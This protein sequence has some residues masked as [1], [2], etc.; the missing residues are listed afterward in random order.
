MGMFPQ[1]NPRE[2]NDPVPSAAPSSDDFSAFM[3]KAM[4]KSM[5][6]SM[7]SAPLRP[8]AVPIANPSPEQP[9]DFSSFAPVQAEQPGVPV[10]TPGFPVN[11]A[12][13]PAEA[14][15]QLI[16]GAL[17]S[18]PKA[19]FDFLKSMFGN[20]NVRADYDGNFYFKKN[21]NDKDFAPVTSGMSASLLRASPEILEIGANIVAQTATQAVGVAGGV[22]GFVAGRAVAPFAGQLAQESARRAVLSSLGVDDLYNFDT[23]DVAS[24]GAFDLGAQALLSGVF[25]GVPALSRFL[26]NGSQKDRASLLAKNQKTVDWFQKEFGSA[27]EKPSDFTKSLF[28]FREEKGLLD[29]HLEKANKELESFILPARQATGDAPVPVGRVLSKL[30]DLLEKAGAIKNP[31][32]GVYSSPGKPLE[33]PETGEVI[34]LNPQK[35]SGAELGQLGGSRYVND[36]IADHAALLSAQRAGGARFEFFD[37]FRKKYGKPAFETEPGPGVKQAYNELYKAAQADRNNY[38]YRGLQGTKDM[39]SIQKAFDRVSGSISDVEMI[40]QQLGSVDAQ[41][42]AAYSLIKKGNP[43]LVRAYKRV[44]GEN[45]AEFS[46]M[47]SLWFDNLVN[48]ARDVVDDPVVL[49]DKLKKSVLSYKPETLQEL[50]IGKAEINK[51]RVA[52]ERFKS[53][54]RRDL[55]TNPKAPSSLLKDVAMLLAGGGVYFKS[56]CAVS[57]AFNLAGGNIKLVDELMNNV[58]PEMA[59]KATSQEAKTSFTEMANNLYKIVNGS[60]REGGKYKP[61][62]TPAIRPYF[63]NMGYEA[64]FRNK[65][66]PEATQPDLIGPEK[67]PGTQVDIPEGK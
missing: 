49:M 24:K 9:Q 63:S 31:R 46:Q 8:Q 7:V 3:P 33:I 28:G 34:G 37:N 48:E 42:T 4:P 66:L 58:L 12:L 13:P 51:F 54:Y 38:V 53:T 30:E 18:N 17:E 20:D 21:K 29:A 32:T 62:P 39:D 35:P 55:M 2:L 6:P 60:V 15:A 67:Q 45:S 61:I 40:R 11:P 47:K 36:M 52:A 41:E 44:L 14:R 5:P 59:E 25:E 23:A 27:P 26:R 19:Q 43:E 16:I 65:K 57:T 1:S 56:K 10:Q 22:P 64:L 50:G